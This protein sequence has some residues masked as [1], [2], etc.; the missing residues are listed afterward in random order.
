MIGL[1][2]KKEINASKI[3][4][5]PASLPSGL[6]KCGP[7]YVYSVWWRKYNKRTEASANALS[8]PETRYCESNCW[9]EL[10]STGLVAQQQRASLHSHCSTDQTSIRT[11]THVYNM[12]VHYVHSV[13][14][15]V[16]V[17][18]YTAQT[19]KNSWS[20]NAWQSLAYSLLGARSVAL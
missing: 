2:L 12:H 10:W 1:Q 17:C 4:S 15:C 20:R 6:N 19:T 13:H 3:Y 8:E 16:C 5:P 18:V 9:V 7:S 14:V 11:L